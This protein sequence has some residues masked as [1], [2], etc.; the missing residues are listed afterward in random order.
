M[1]QLVIGVLAVAALLSPRDSSGL[2]DPAPSTLPSQPWMA[3]IFVDDGGTLREFCK[4]ALIEDEWVLTTGYCI[5]DPFEALGPER[6][7]TDAEYVVRFAGSQELHAVAKYV[8]SSD[9][10]VALMKLEAPVAITPVALSRSTAAEL[11]DKDVFILGTEI[12]KA[13]GDYLFN[14]DFGQRMYCRVD[15]EAFYR[16]G[17]VCYI[18]PT[19]VHSTSLVETRAVVINPSAPGAPNS[20]L[21]TGSPF[22]T[23][24]ARLYLD[25]RADH[26]YPCHEDLGAPILR[27]NDSGTVEV[28]GIVSGVGMAIG[29]P[30]CNPSLGNLFATASAYQDFIDTTLA[31]E[32]FD[33]L[34]PAT[35]ELK[36]EYPGGRKI[37]LS[38]PAVPGAT[39]YRLMYNSMVGYE[40]YI[41]LD[42]GNRTEV[43]TEILPDPIYRVAAV[44]YNG[45]CSSPISGELTVAL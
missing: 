19:L 23:T 42:L 17:A 45:T 15:G 38:W 29:F 25:F 30:L 20:P 5:Y 34:C 18:M 41:T 40:A 16:P 9:Y 39:G 12:S 37:R 10:T 35:P 32:A 11:L 33:A 3:Q 6:D 43:N 7:G 36:V 24:G 13:V 44:S 14:P 27:V 8:K 21:D 1:R 31:Q 2:V 4:G 22:D 28:A 26:S